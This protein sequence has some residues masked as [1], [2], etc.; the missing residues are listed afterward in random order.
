MRY[1][2]I[3]TLP[4]DQ[5][6]GILRDSRRYRAVHERT[7]RRVAEQALRAEDG[8]VRAAA[9]RAKRSLHQ[10]FGAYL[11]ERPRYDRLL[12]AF[13]AAAQARDEAAL[14]QAARDAMQC[15]A[16]T[17][18]RLSIVEQFYAAIFQRLGPV[19]RVLDLACGLNPLALPW[20]GLPPGHRYVAVDVDEALIAFVGAVLE[21]FGASGEARVVDVVEEPVEDEADVALLLKLWPCL[22]RQ[23]PTAPL[24]LVRRVRAPR[25]VVSF[26]TQSIGGRNKGM[27]ENYSAAFERAMRDEPFTW[28]RLE[29]PGELAYVLTRAT[30]VPGARA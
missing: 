18:E 17:R 29:F 23:R 16:S 20:M 27:R 28:E 11:P 9:K 2:E 15:H 12:A 10:M 13:D 19:Q 4:I 21:R 30:H 5:L 25:L 1:D 24:E 22:E 14:R 26:P 6:V 7:L 3:V 8:H